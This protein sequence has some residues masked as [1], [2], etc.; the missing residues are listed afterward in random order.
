MANSELDGVFEYIPREVWGFLVP[1]PGFDRL[2]Q[3]KH[4]HSSVLK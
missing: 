1:E 2:P 4:L 3:V